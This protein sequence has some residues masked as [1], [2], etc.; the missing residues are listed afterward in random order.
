MHLLIAAIVGFNPAAIHIM[1]SRARAIDDVH[2]KT[3]ARN[4]IQTGAQFGGNA[5]IENARMNSRHQPQLF[6]DRRKSGRKNPGI[7]IRPEPAL[8]DERDVKA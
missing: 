3:P 4:A 8:R 1:F 5:R 2:A 6:H 7:E